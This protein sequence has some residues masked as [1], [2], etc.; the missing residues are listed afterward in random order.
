M[1]KLDWNDTYMSFAKNVAVHSKANKAKVGCV[2]VKD[3]QVISTGYNGTPPGYDN[4][5]EDSG[6]TLPEVV[7]AE[8]NAITKV[9]RS[10]VSCEKA[11]LY[12]TKAP[13]FECAK[14]IIMAGIDLVVF[15]GAY[16]DC[17]RDSIAFLQTNHVTVIVMNDG[18][19]YV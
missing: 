14:A 9:A 16:E 17:E 4:T 15:E 10:T 19:Y 7:H 12:V 3:N 18:S 2:I 5:C 8:I 11:S 13:C 6:V 1:T